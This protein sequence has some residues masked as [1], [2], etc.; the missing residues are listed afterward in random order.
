[1]L[2]DLVKWL[3]QS[4]QFLMFTILYDIFIQT[5]DNCYYFL[6]STNVRWFWLTCRAEVLSR[7]VSVYNTHNRVPRWIIMGGSLLHFTCGRWK[8]GA[9]CLEFRQGEGA[10][11]KRIY[12]T[13]IPAN[14]TCSSHIYRLWQPGKDWSS[15]ST[16]P[17]FHLKKSLYPR[18]TK[19]KEEEDASKTNGGGKDCSII[20]PTYLA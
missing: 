16:L 19:Q 3:R 4:W 14:I 18:L 7:S 10:T 17:R 12:H 13:Y 9:K 15:L 20:V 11:T 6:C 1:M 2:T 5:Q 8:C